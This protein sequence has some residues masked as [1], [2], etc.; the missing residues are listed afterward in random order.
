MNNYE[1]NIIIQ[2]TLALTQV[3]KLVEKVVK[4]IKKDKGS[5]VYQ[6]APEM[7]PLAYPIQKHEKGYYQVL[8]FKAEPS[9][10][11]SLEVFYKREEDILR[12]ITIAL[13]KHAVAYNQNKRKS[14]KKSSLSTT[15]SKEEATKSNL[16]KKKNSFS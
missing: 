16:Q 8:E 9:F 15:S 6:P 5:I 10:I 4:M 3:K 7:R 11:A 2:P 12:Y 13:N 14:K 1:T